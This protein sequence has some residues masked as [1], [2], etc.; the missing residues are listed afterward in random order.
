MGFLRIPANRQKLAE[1]L[2][3]ATGRKIE[4]RD[5]VSRKAP[6]DASAQAPAKGGANLRE[7]LNQPAVRLALEVFPDATV[8]NIQPRKQDE[9]PQKED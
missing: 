6:D 8:M 9:P 2:S 5:D 3:R 1:L 4:V 7:A